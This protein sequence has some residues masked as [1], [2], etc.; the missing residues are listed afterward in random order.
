MWPV[1]HDLGFRGLDADAL[2][3]SGVQRCDEPDAAKVR[4]AI[5]VAIRA[6][7]RS[8]CV[9]RVAQEF[10]DH[11]E[12][13]VIRMRWALNMVRD[14]FAEPAPGLRWR[15]DSAGLMVLGSQRRDGQAADSP[16]AKWRE[17][18]GSLVG[19]KG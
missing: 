7:G 19:G 12:T 16:G 13:A 1:M 10:G 4:Q 3:A 5:A 2:F 6:F 11:P 9:G 14:A 18:T 15:R 8:G 17:R